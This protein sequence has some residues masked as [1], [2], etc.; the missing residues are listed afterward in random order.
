MSIVCLYFK[1]LDKKM[2]TF[3]YF[4]GDKY[5]K[6]GCKCN[7]SSSMTIYFVIT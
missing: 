1:S 2:E 5:N 3:V 6:E 7:T 4:F